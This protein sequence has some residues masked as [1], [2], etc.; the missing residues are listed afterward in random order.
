MDRYP[1]L[2]IFIILL[3]G[4]LAASAF[5]IPFIFSGL[6]AAAALLLV[7]AGHR[8]GI[9]TVAPGLSLTL[10]AAG[11]ASYQTRHSTV[12]PHWAHGSQQIL[13]A[14]IISEPRRTDR[15]W[16]FVSRTIARRSGG[17]WQPADRKVMTYIGSPEESRPEYGDVLTVEGIWRKAAERRNPGG[18]DYRRYLERQEVSGIF[19][20]SRHRII[21]HSRGNIVVSG[22]II[23]LRR[24]V[25]VTIERYLGGDPGSLLAGLLLGE[26]YNLSRPVR[27]AFSDTGTAHVLA[28]S[29]LH[30]ALMAFIIFI[31]LRLLQLPKRAAS[32]GTAAG[33]A[34]YTLLAG[35]SP[36]IVRSSIMV[37][38]VLLGGLFE[39]RGNG[40]N[41]LGLAGL[42]ILAF[43]PDAA[44]DIG[45]QLSFAATAGILILTRP[46]ESLLF[47]TWGS[48]L[49]RKWILTPL[50]VSLAAQIFTAPLLAWYF[51]RIPLISL[52]AN[53][54]VVPLTGLIL[55][56]ALAMV[57][58]N[59]LGG[60]VSWPIAASAYLFSKIML[61]SVS[62]FSRLKLGTI[63]W[64]TVSWPQLA[65]YAG[66]CLLPFLWRRAGKPRLAAI[67]VV[68]A[69][70][71]V[72]V[73]QQA[74]ARPA[75]L[76][77]TFLDVGQGDCALVEM[78]N[79]ARYL[80]D[81]G[82][83][84]PTRDS[85]RDVILP[86]LRAR[87]ITR[88]DN[89]VISHSDADHCGGLSYL[90]DHLDI[91]NLVISDHPSSQPMFN[92]ALEQARTGNVPLQAVS[93]Y[94]TLCGIWPARGFLYS[95]EDLTP[96]GNESSLILYLQYGRTNILFVG[97]MGPELEDILLQ[98]GLLGR[99]RVL[100]VPHHGARP[101]NPEELAEIIRPELAV[102]SVGEDNR[103]GH[104]AREAVENYTAIGSTVYRTDLCGA[105]IM[106]SDGENITCKSM[107]E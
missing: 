16:R 4:V 57:L 64:P 40:L 49:A 94:D 23:P 67:S 83:C 78:P 91:R 73:W 41:M 11:L 101:N 20:A 68:M 104:P 42:L 102:I 28:V 47:R 76:R 63:N 55:A 26:R 19:T 25:R 61:E 65:L 21:S 46:I 13:L 93:G 1:A 3:L 82:L 80:I 32:L 2:K 100:K 77:V 89:V 54:V 22:L 90:L 75:G 38:A 79:G 30:A 66:I 6:L 9:K 95:R 58:L 60:W 27:E 8:F 12:P 29:G 96:N 51:H 98:K 69:A 81:A 103:F 48:A 53:L 59:L 50:A 15:G 34:I 43:W 71:A 24:Y 18:C 72:L 92:R 5:R 97:D 88:L 36:S 105:V 85:G 44:W 33:L 106:E 74:L 99:C 70:A 39:R 35:A 86:F 84:T 107:I 14:K 10:L 17:S 87:G 7:W 31:I 62:F 52:V 37:G 45:F 56:L